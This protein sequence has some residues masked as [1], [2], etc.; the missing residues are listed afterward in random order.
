MNVIASRRSLTAGLL[1]ACVA[2]PARAQAPEATLDRIARTGIMRV[3]AVP[4]QPPYS[5]RD[6]ATGEWAGFMVDIARDLAAEHGARIEPVETTWGN[7]VLDVVSDKVDIFFGLAPTPQRA[8]AVDFSQPLYQNAFSL[9][10]REGFAPQRWQDLNKPEVRVALELGTV[11]DQNVANLCPQATV[12]RLKTNNDALLALQA[13]RADCQML[14]V[15]LAL[16]T[17]ART[18]S[19]GHLI[20]PEP[21][22][23]SA[24][25]A[26][27]AKA[28]TP[29]WRDAVD[30]WI[31][32]RR[33]AGKLRQVLVA[34]LEKVGVPAS[35]VPPQLLF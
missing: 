9:I 29:A 23:G 25:S 34:N 19:L 14:V 18:P 11:Y 24:T 16:T 32:R 31:G 10:A 6:A 5:Y 8:L 12:I 35:A 4:A 27:M 15:I 22:F 17:L 2:R 7:A 21:Q 1:A 30:A 13:G 28:P 26:I 3:G 20:V 33:A